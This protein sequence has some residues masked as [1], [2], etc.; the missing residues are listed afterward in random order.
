MWPTLGRFLE[1]YPLPFLEIY[2]VGYWARQL[3]LGSGID[4]EPVKTPRADEDYS[5]GLDHMVSSPCDAR[6]SMLFDP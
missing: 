3:W 4:T 5:H 2:G 6:Q 1:I